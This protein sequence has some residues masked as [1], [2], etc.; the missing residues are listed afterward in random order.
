L[1]HTDVDV[2]GYAIGSVED[3]S[4]TTLVAT[5][6][7][8]DHQGLQADIVYEGE[9]YPLKAA[10]LGDFNLSNLLAATACLIAL[11][12]SPEQALRQ[13]AKVTTVPGRIEK[14]EAA[15]HANRE[16]H[17]Q[18]F[19]AVVD[20]AHTPGALESVLKALR[21][22][23]QGQLICAFGCGGDR[24]KGKRPLMAAVAEKLA[25][26]V[27]VTDDN[28]RNE[29]PQQ[30]VQEIMSGFEQAEFVT[31]EH[32]R[33]VAISQAIALAKAGD[34]VLVAGKGHE[35]SQLVQGKALPFDDREQIRF[36]LA[37]LSKRAVA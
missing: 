31:V 9:V 7:Q 3:F 6:A 34:V 30:I 4:P 5:N 29:D 28:P 19:L 23:C 20:Y 35:Q 26:K 25:D 11:G 8:F 14:I 32:D 24:D 2:Y 13:I 10:V 12:S 15:P 22:H 27:I 17:S 21:A 37:K 16:S 36:A 18:P 1:Q 33:A